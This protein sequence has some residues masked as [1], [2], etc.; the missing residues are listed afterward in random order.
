MLKDLN[1]PNPYVSSA[2]SAATSVSGESG[3][4]MLGPY[5]YVSP[6]Y[7]L[8]AHQLGGAYGFN[9]ETGPGPAVPPVESL[10]NF[11]PPEHMWPIDSWWSFHAG[12]GNFRTLDV[13]NQA[14]EKRYGTSSNLNEYTMRSQ[15]MS[16]EGERAMFEAFGKNKY[17]STGVIQWMLNNAWPSLIWHLYDYY[18]RPG[19]SYFGA[20]KGCEPLHI[21]YAYDDS[22]IVVVNS[23]R[24]DFANLTA[25]VEVLNFDLSSQFSKSVHFDIKSDAVNKLFTIPSLANLSETYFIR[26]V[27]TNPKGTVVSNNF[28]WLPRQPDVLDFANSTW[29]LTPTTTFG[30]LQSLNKLPRTHLQSKVSV[31][32]NSSETTATVTLKNTGHSLAFAIDLRLNSNKEEILPVRWEDNY[33]SL[34]P[35]ESR[36]I[37][38]HFHTHDWNKRPLTL[39]VRGWNTD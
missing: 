31:E 32:S 26:L 28:Y 24:Q 19:G 10:Q 9:T 20:K 3:V 30:S 23:Y 35:G 2:T 39:L 22:S 7:W 21:Q 13:F 34:L 15:L 17:V 4:K 1:W 25:T 36:S 11:L 18:L 12:G 29:Y 38:A 37:Q 27:L 14:L 5:D 8:T 6:T 16:Y 33:I